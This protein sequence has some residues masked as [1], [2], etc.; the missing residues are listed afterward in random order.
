[1]PPGTYIINRQIM[2]GCVAPR[3][4]TALPCSFFQGDQEGIGGAGGRARKLS[5]FFVLSFA[6]F[7]LVFFLSTFE[8]E[9][10]SFVYPPSWVDRRYKRFLGFV[11]IGAIN[12]VDNRFSFAN[13][14]ALF[15]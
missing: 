2:S 8:V 7:S 9:G 14:E 1:M 5:F 3:Y 11:Q 13:A 4:Q 12:Q 6:F 10:R 15:C